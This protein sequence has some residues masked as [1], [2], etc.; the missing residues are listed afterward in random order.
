MSTAQTTAKLSFGLIS[1]TLLS[2][3]P[4]FLSLLHKWPKR[5]L[6]RRLDFFFLS[7]L[8][9]LL[10]VNLKTTLYI[11]RYLKKKKE[12]KKKLI[13]SPNDG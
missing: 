8:L 12:K 11:S 13:Y 3:P 2:P 5:R 4:V 6:I 7:S 10:K 1:I 9:L